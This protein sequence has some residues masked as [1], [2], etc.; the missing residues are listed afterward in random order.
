M[1]IA[2]ILEW[3]FPGMAL[4]GYELVGQPDG[5]VV[6]SRWDEAIMGVPKPTDSD[7]A[8]W[9]LPAAKA[10]KKAEFSERAVDIMEAQFPEV[11]TRKAIWVAVNLM[12]ANA[13][14][15]RLK[16]VRDT[17]DKLGR[18]HAEVDSKTTVADVLA[19]TWESVA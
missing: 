5:S 12:M 17:R 7:I 15:T 19:L 4:V 16:T 9:E 13:T 14:D 2:Q 11:T 6:I 8:S 10:R 18:A 3:R 1:N